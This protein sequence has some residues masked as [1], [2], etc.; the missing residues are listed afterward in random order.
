M[1]RLKACPIV[2]VAQDTIFFHYTTHPHMTGLGPIGAKSGE[3]LGLLGAV[4]GVPTRQP[5]CAAPPPNRHNV[6]CGRQEKGGILVNL[7]PRS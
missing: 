4:P 2:L 5:R 1:E 3:A 6:I 7:T